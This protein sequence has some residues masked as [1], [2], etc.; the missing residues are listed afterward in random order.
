M[1]EQLSGL[2]TDAAWLESYAA[3]TMLKVKE[4]FQVLAACGSPPQWHCECNGLVKISIV[5]GT[6][7]CQGMGG[8][9]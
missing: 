2:V 7:C 1:W 3:A 4:A 9:A 6:S 8:V 5:S